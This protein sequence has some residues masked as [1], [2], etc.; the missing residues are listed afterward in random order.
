MT[1]V[2]AGATQC[3]RID[4]EAVIVRTT[5]QFRPAGQRALS[6]VP[7]AQRSAML[8][9]LAAEAAP[10]LGAV[11][12]GKIAAGQITVKEAV[13]LRS[14]SM[15]HLGNHI[16]ADQRQRLV[17]TLGMAAVTVAPQELRAAACSRNQSASA[18]CPGCC[19]WCGSRC[20]VRS[21]RQRH[22]PAQTKCSM[23]AAAVADT[24]KI[25]RINSS[26]SSSQM[27]FYTA[28]KKHPG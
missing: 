12:V 10:P 28:V 16:N 3:V 20:T 9:P 23:I 13:T 15:I 4:N 8:C 14:I 26:P 2:G 17:H 1:A 7:T 25:L 22:C 18:G 6:S 21:S 19:A 24:W 5:G 27:L 11:D